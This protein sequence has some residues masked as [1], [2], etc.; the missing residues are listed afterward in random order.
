[1]EKHA[2]RT[3]EYSNMVTRRKKLFQVYVLNYLMFKL[4]RLINFPVLKQ[5]YRY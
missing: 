4:N 1:M 3:F 5:I 2:G